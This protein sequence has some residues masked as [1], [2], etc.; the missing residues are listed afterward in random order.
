MTYTSKTS[1]SLPTAKF[2][3][4]FKVGFNKVHWSNEEET[5]L[6]LKEVIFP[7]ITK[8]KKKLKLPQN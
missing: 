8:V 4:G 2:P 6:L 5:L 7:Y 3:E 1:R